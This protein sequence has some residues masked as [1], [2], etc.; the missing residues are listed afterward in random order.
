MSV[1]VLALDNVIANSSNTD[2]ILIIVTRNGENV[3]WL[4]RQT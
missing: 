3:S 1:Y 2:S 4:V